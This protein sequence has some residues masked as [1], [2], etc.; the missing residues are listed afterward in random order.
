MI[1]G[2]IALHD[3]NIPWLK[4]VGELCKPL[5]VIQKPRSMEFK[6]IVKDYFVVGEKLG[7]GK[8]RR[9]SMIISSQLDSKCVVTDGD[10]QYPPTSIEKFVEKMSTMEDDVLIPQRTNRR[11]M[12]KYGDRVLDR[13]EFERFESYCV[14]EYL[15]TPNLPDNLDA[16]PGMFGFKS[17]VVDKILP[18]DNEWLADWEITAKALKNTRV[19]FLPLM[20]DPTVQGV[21]LFSPDDQKAKLGKIRRILGKPLLQV[22]ERYEANIRIEERRILRA[23]L[24]ETEAD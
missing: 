22:Y 18:N 14:L 19:A 13:G 24:S 6:D 1:I 21:T 10:G 9:L 12:V 15:R 4:A 16:Q 20:I 7:F 8:A 5:L 3:V 2:I 17:K 23:W 11:V